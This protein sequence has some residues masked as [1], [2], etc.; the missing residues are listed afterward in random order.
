MDHRQRMEHLYGNT[1]GAANTGGYGASGTYVNTSLNKGNTTTYNYNN[2]TYV[3]SN[4]FVTSPNA[5]NIGGGGG[6]GG[7]NGSINAS[8][9][10]LALAILEQGIHGTHREVL[11]PLLTQYGPLKE[12]D[13]AQVLGM[14]AATHGSLQAPGTTLPTYTSPHSPLSP[15]TTLT[16]S[17]NVF[18][19]LDAIMER[20]PYLGWSGV[21]RALD[22]PEFYVS[23]YKGAEMLIKAFFYATKN[24]Q[25]FPV[26]IF[27]TTPWRNISGQL[28]FIRCALLAPLDLI[29]FAKAGRRI[30][31]AED[32]DSYS[33]GPTKN[34]LFHLLNQ[35]WNSLELIE[36]LCSVTDSEFYG[37]VRPIFEIA[38][39]Q[40][41]ELLCLGL[42][43]YDPPWNSTLHT[44]LVK[45]ISGFLTGQPSSPVVLP[46][47]WRIHSQL[48]LL[49]M[50]ELHRIDPTCISRLLDIAQELKILPKVLEAKP[51]SFAI[52]M[53]ALA[54]RREH[55]N[56]EK[57]LTDAMLKFRDPFIRATLEFLLEKCFHA[58]SPQRIII[59]PSPDV[60]AIFLR[61]LASQQ[62]S[63][64]YENLQLY[65]EIQNGLHSNGAN[66]AALTGTVTP[67]V[68]AAL[69][70]GG[71]G[72]GGGGGPA[73]PTVVP[74]VVGL[75]QPK[76]STSPTTAASLA[77]MM[78]EYQHPIFLEFF[79]TT[80]PKDI[81]EEANSCYEKI[82]SHEVSVH[83]IID[84]MS[85]LKNSYNPRD[86]MVFHCMI[87]N[88]LDEYRFF[89]KYPEKELTLTG[90]IFGLLIHHLLLTETALG[91]ALRFILDA[92][93]RPYDSKMFKFGLTALMQ[94]QGR[95]GE[96]PP[97]CQH[98][99]EIPSLNSSPGGGNTVM[100]EL[101]AYIQ[102]TFAHSVHSRD[103]NNRQ[104][105]PIL[106]FLEKPG[107]SLNVNPSTNIISSNAANANP[108]ANANANVFNAY[109]NNNSSCSNTHPASG[110]LSMQQLQYQPSVPASM[111]GFVALLK[112]A[113]VFERDLARVH[114]LGKED[115]P[116]DSI[117]EKFMFIL[118]NISTSNFGSKCKELEVLVQQ[119]GPLVYRWLASIL[120]GKRIA[121]E[122]NNHQ[123]YL[124]LLPRQAS[125]SLL[126]LQLFVLMELYVRIRELLNA[127]Q[128][129]SSSNDRTTLKNL[130]S[131]LG[132]FTLARDKPILFAYLPLKEILLEA[133]QIDRLLVAIPFVC[134]V[135]E[136]CRHSVRVFSRPTTNPWSMSILGLLVE[137][138]QY[139]DLKLN[140]KFEIEVLCKSLGVELSEICP[141]QYLLKTRAALKYQ[142]V[143][144]H[145]VTH[146]P[147]SLSSSSSHVSS[148]LPN[149]PTS[150]SQSSVTG[151]S[152]SA[153]AHMMG[154]P[155]HLTTSPA[156]DSPLL[157]GLLAMIEG[158]L[159]SHKD[160]LA[161][162]LSAEAMNQLKRLMLLV[163]EFS[164]RQVG[165]TMVDR[166]LS[167]AVHTTKSLV[168]KDF[169]YEGSEEN[170]RMASHSLLQLLVTQLILGTVRESLRST[171]Y[172]FHVLLAVAVPSLNL[173][174]AVI[175][176]LL[177]ALVDPC[178]I[179]LEQVGYRKALLELNAQLA[180]SFIL[181]R[182][183]TSLLFK[184]PDA[185]VLLDAA[186]AAIKLPEGLDLH[187][188][189]LSETQLALYGDLA[190]RNSRILSYSV[191]PKV[192]V[193]LHSDSLTAAVPN[194]SILP[195]VT[196]ADVDRAKASLSSTVAQQP[197]LLPSD[198]VHAAASTTEGNSLLDQLMY[199]LLSID[200]IISSNPSAS[201]SSFPSDHELRVHMKQILVLALNTSIN[202][203][204]TCLLFTTKIIHVLY[205]TESVLG[206]EVHVV[207]LDKLCELSSRVTKQVVSWVKELG[208]DMRKWNVPV[209]VAFFLAGL[210]NVLEYDQA[211]SKAI[212]AVSS[213]SRRDG[214]SSSSDGSDGPINTGIIDFAM[215]LIN[216]CVLIDP[217]VASPFDFSFT[218][219]VLQSLRSAQALTDPY[220][221]DVAD[222]LAKV[223]QKKE[224]IKSLS[225]SLLVEQV[226]YYYHE[227][228][229]LNSLIMVTEKNFMN[230]VHQVYR[231]GF[232]REQGMDVLFFKELV[233]LTIKLFKE[234][235]ESSNGSAS[236]SSRSLENVAKW[237]VFT[238]RTF[239]DDKLALFKKFMLVLGKVMIPQLR[240]EDSSTQQQQQ[241]Q[242]HEDAEASSSS[243]QAFFTRF[244]G[245]LI[246]EVHAQERH[247]TSSNASLSTTT[248]GEPQHAD[249]PLGLYHLL[250]EWLHA[251]RPSILPEF[252]FGWLELMSHRFLLPKLLMSASPTNAGP[253]PSTAAPENGTEAP[254][255]R[256]E[257]RSWRLVHLLLR[258]ALDFIRPFL[259]GT[260][261]TMTP[262][263]RLYYK[264]ILRIFLL[265][266][267]DF[268]EF[269]S[270]YHLSLS[271]LIP[272]H[273]IQLRNLILSAFP[274]H[275]KLLDPF[276]PNL[277]ME[278]LPES[279]VMPS[280]F[281]S[282]AP[283]CEK[284]LAQVPS[285]VKDLEAI[286]ASGGVIQISELR[287]IQAKS[288]FKD[289]STLSTFLEDAGKAS[290]IHLTLLNGLLYSILS[291]FLGSVASNGGVGKAV[292]EKCVS[293]AVRLLLT[294]L[295]VHSSSSSE[296]SYALFN[297]MINQLR[298]PNLD[299][300]F[301]SMV[302]L[303][304]FSHPLTLEKHREQ[305]TRVL[306]ERLIVNRPHPWGLLVTFMELIRNSKYNF[307]NH[308][309]THFSPDIEKLFDSVAKS[310]ML[311][312]V[313]RTPVAT[314]I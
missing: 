291:S 304:L 223:A 244:V 72:G 38:S 105:H 203:D 11:G 232:F 160:D 287:S 293:I 184:D 277:R 169:V 175:G 121:N 269:L 40:C 192:E 245:A 191:A 41:P 272:L 178:S 1:N 187:R 163:V 225:R 59:P 80:Y 216:R 312:L 194:S 227:W 75:Q 185:P 23:D 61:A 30:I 101:Y 233:A 58:S 153:A 165:A 36:L 261:L 4:N 308:E 222:F 132:N 130:G 268:P 71:G 28:A 204:E 208:L 37:E 285:F 15:N 47:L 8:I 62:A 197:L 249:V 295:L 78:D 118:N 26:G 195:A 143:Q 183:N 218:L 193:A 253:P 264:A 144:P 129:T 138:Y 125:P 309:F 133:Y 161:S 314:R 212:Q 243:S 260:S 73:G 66:P 65:H 140:L 280:L 106:Y 12:S 198:A 68:Q 45:L 257:P 7:G 35:H 170:L 86:N 104:V 147:P 282:L 173:S 172:E 310:C 14:M 89:P 166:C 226:H 95:L 134:K 241:Q 179:I 152:A 254:S 91:I 137:L 20:F 151:T 207:L 100:A 142:R 292:P 297:F 110:V 199:H 158:V 39:K 148:A 288:V 303:S 111:L 69:V 168:L 298:Y 256:E 70:S 33:N 278:N 46:R 228:Q 56:L 221:A 31:A 188:N 122:A 108:N 60:L 64:S 215:A 307:W 112:E 313:K 283:P 87:H 124:D 79:G 279:G 220:K 99:M 44:C 251:L 150:I 266:L 128:T 210:V 57:W 13:V 102:S 5:S 93:K 120:V 299:T 84:T 284:L 237:I 114:G 156:R 171:L 29:S 96:W 229:R 17:W 162:L 107:Q 206:I 174:D 9:N 167:V 149:G 258:H 190:V 242:P 230:F 201:F 32:I 21:M 76:A 10:S 275:L 217:V 205:K 213:S 305:I 224:S 116:E 302:L 115:P 274:R 42:A 119:H 252:A 200:A 90:I 219:D 6:G 54:S 246:I 263:L 271:S 273:C 24:Q 235:A 67:A 236:S 276:T 214:T 300:S 239:P 182:Q 98:L 211:L 139:T 196:P 83:D 286:S 146:L 81:E 180:G 43:C 53:A 289:L 209:T 177:D 164:V 94:F 2:H 259:I 74:V 296:F 311:P 25:E 77:S 113:A 109:G 176:S 181:R 50:T 231:Q 18:E 281:N 159:L 240:Q 255:G 48:M 49:C 97:Y 189:G 145:V 306:L 63:M 247:F 123:L 16:S 135:L 290:S 248:E 117:Q 52:D 136:A 103:L 3:G 154:E 234:E 157:H 127:E 34:A 19:F 22:Y 265:L 250:A 88:L 82:Y 238:L 51:F 55:L 85:R 202:R 267:H 131:F 126:T 186:A 301:F 141:W 27:C 270:S 92:L 155:S 294:L 262:A